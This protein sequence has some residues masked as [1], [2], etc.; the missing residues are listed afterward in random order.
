MF[1]IHTVTPIPNIPHRDLTLLHYSATYRECCV[2]LDCAVNHDPM[3]AAFSPLSSSKRNSVIIV[4]EMLHRLNSVET[5]MHIPFP[6]E[7]EEKDFVLVDG[8][9]FNGES[10]AQPELGTCF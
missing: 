3:M 10:D 6:D 1:L 2:T 7:E 8:F 5:F 4:R 9:F